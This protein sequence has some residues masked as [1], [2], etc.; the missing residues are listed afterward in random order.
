[1]VPMPTHQRAR[2]GGDWSF[3]E[4]PLGSPLLW[5]YSPQACGVSSCWVTHPNHIGIALSFP[6]KLNLRWGSFLMGCAFPDTP[7][8]GKMWGEQTMS[9]CLVT[10]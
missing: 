10:L 9:V 3:S 7:R 6:V 1:M 5:H 8:G 4:F 2:F